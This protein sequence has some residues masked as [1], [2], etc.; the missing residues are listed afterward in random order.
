MN[1]KFL[2]PKDKSPLSNCSEPCKDTFVP[3]PLCPEL[4]DP[5]TYGPFTAPTT[6][7]TFYDYP[8]DN[9]SLVKGCNNNCSNKHV[10]AELEYYVY[11]IIEGVEYFVGTWLIKDKQGPNKKEFKECGEYIL[12]F[13]SR[14]PNECYPNCDHPTPPD[15]IELSCNKNCDPY[16]DSATG[17]TNPD[18]EPFNEF[19]ITIP[20]CCKI[21]VQVTFESGKVNDFDLPAQSSIY[22]F[23]SGKFCENITD[24]VFSGSEKCIEKLHVIVKR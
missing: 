13:C 15:F 11:Q 5:Y 2:P 8:N 24:I 10:R 21:N 22:P 19:L 6:I 17:E 4:C 3:T 23:D 18:F 12:R 20:K 1:N 9:T 14:P 16:I 7:S